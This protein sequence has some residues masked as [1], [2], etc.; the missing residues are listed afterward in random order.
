MRILV[1]NSG[2]SGDV[3]SGLIH[4]SAKKATQVKDSTFLFDCDIADETEPL[5]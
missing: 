4:T 1:A 5:N 3:S 2:L